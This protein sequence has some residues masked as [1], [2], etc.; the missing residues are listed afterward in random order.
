MVDGKGLSIGDSREVT[1]IR[2][3]FR[4]RELRRV[5]GINATIWF[6]YKDA[7]GDVTGLA[8]GLPA[9]GGR[10]IE[11]LGLG[12]FGLEVIEQVPL[13]VGHTPENAR[14]LETKRVKLGH[15]LSIS[16]S[17]GKPPNAD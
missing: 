11:G 5:T 9:G 3:N 13:E 1:G 2:L 10:R 15:H 7:R 16:P 4:D 12:A 8:L 14:Y 6:P 17:R